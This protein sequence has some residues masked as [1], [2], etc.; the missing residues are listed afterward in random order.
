MTYRLLLGMALGL[1]P[2]AIQAQSVVSAGAGSYAST[3]PAYKS[4]TDQHEGFN[5]G[6]ML[7]RKI[8]C[9]ER[10]GRA[11]PTNDWWTDLINNRFSGSMWSYPAML[12]TGDYGV[13]ICY[14]SYWADEGKEI[15][16]RTSV[17]VSALSFSPEAAVASDW[18][19]LD[20]V[21][22]M[23]DKRNNGAEMKV[24]MAHGVPFTWFEYDSLVPALSFSDTPEFFGENK[25]K[26]F[27]GVRI[28]DDLYG[29]YYPAGLSLKES[30][31][32]YAL[33]DAGWVVVALLRDES[34][35]ERF[36]EYAP[37]VIRDSRISWNY[38]ERTSRVSSEWNIET[39]NL[40]KPGESTPVLLGL[41]PH[42]YKYSSTLPTAVNGLSYE[43]PRGEM[44]M[45]SDASGRFAYDCA[46]SG[47]LPYYAAPEENPDDEA[48]YSAEIMETLM[49]TYADK[50]T[51]GKDTYW[52]GKGL[53]QMALNMT[54]ARESG[55]EELYLKSR[56]KLKDALVDWLTYTPGEESCFFSYYP[57]WGSMLGFNVSYDSDAF[58]DHHF[59]YGYFTYAAALLCMEDPSFAADYGEI[60]TLIA[61]DY[62]NYDRQDT[63][64]PFL[65]TL[66]PWCGHSWAG[67]LGD[68]G[69]DNGNGQESTSE[70]MQS[71]GGLYLLGV[72][73]GDKE[74]RD[75]GIWGWNTEARATREYWFDVD[76]VRPANA[77]GRKPWA[78]KGDRKGNYDYSQY[79]YAYNSNI[80]GKGIGW[81]T[82]FGGDPL[83]MHGIQWMPVSPAL[84]YLSWDNDFVDWAYDDMMTGAN[85]TFSHEWF[86]PTYNTDNGDV[87][88]P[89]ADNDWGNVTLA[90]MQRSRPQE[91]AEIF[92]RAYKENRHIA[93]AVST[94]HI[95]YYL[96]HHHLTYGD[97]DFS[98]N[99]DIPTASAYLKD[100][101]YTFMVY[102]PD[103]DEKRV[104]F[105]RSGV[106]LKSVLAPAGRLTAFDAEP[107]ASSIV[108]E[109]SEGLIIPPGATTDITARVLDQ[110]GATAEK[111]GALAF[112]SDNAAVDVTSTGRV[113]VKAGAVKGT[114]FTITVTAGDLTE[115]LVFNIN[116][117]PVATGYHI[118]GLPEYIEKGTAFE[119]V[120]E[121]TDQ[122][123][124][125]TRPEVREWRLE[126]EDTAVSF[127]NRH[128]AARPGNFTL[129]AIIGGAPVHTADVTVLPQLPNAALEATAYSS[130]EENVGSATANVNDGDSGTRWGSRHTED[131]WVLLDFGEETYMTGAVVDWEAA[132]GSDYDFQVAPEGASM[133][134][135]TGSYAGV[136]RTITVPAESEWTTVAEVRG[137]SGAGKVSTS[138]NATGRYLRLK[139][140]TRGSAYG[141]SIHEMNVRG[142]PTSLSNNAPLGIDF[143]LPEVVDQNERVALTPKIYDKSGAGRPV[144]VNWSADKE[145]EFDGNTFVPLDY[146]TYELT[147]R[148][149]DG[150]FSSGSLFVNEG[151]RMGA[152]NFTP[153]APEGVT[154]DEISLVLSAS[155]QFGGLFDFTGID[156]KIVVTD[157]ATGKVADPSEVRYDWRNGIFRADRKGTYKVS[158]NDG[159]A[160]AVVSVMDVSE[161]NLAL[162][163]PATASASNGGNDAAKINDGNLGTRW[164]SPAKDNQWVEIDLENSYL[165]DHTV[166][167]WEG[168]YAK[169]YSLSVSTDGEN[170]WTVCSYKEG[171]GGTE[172]LALPAVPARFIRLDCER[173]A[174]VWGNS[175]YEWEVYGSARFETEDDGKAPLVDVLDADPGNGDVT[176]TLSAT[177]D[178]GY[179]YGRFEL[180]YAAGGKVGEETAAFISGES[181]SRTFGNLDPNQ[182]YVVT[183][184]VTDPFGNEVV[185][186]V[187]FRSTLDLT[188]KNIALGK[189]ATATSRENAGLDAEYAVDGDRS[190]RWGSEFR[191]NE[192]LD[193]DLGNVYSLTQIAI[194]WDQT[195]YS[196]DYEVEG[197]E[198]GSS[199][200]PIFS[201]EGWNGQATGDGCRADVFDIP[202]KTYARYLR[203]TSTKRATQ[204]GSSVREFEVYADNDF[205][206]TLTGV[207]TAGASALTDGRVYNLQG[208]AV[209]NSAADLE[210]NPLP[211]GIYITGGRKFTVTD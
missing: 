131:E 162:G 148:T 17:T 36:A 69:N 158:V 22:R 111:H 206:H 25:S 149:T 38:D 53:I 127:A 103:A 71:W 175:L 125:V 50:G 14:P 40:R 88:E 211:A 61:K 9:D 30:R 24:T 201:R 113:S 209:R 101:S 57:R 140:I 153:A 189:T 105:Y 45:Y 191:D 155:N 202:V 11:I 193:I 85:S 16:S 99:A 12:Q 86:T 94:G 67:G 39:D 180:A 135:Y 185:K 51:F 181:V 205:D 141:Y 23:P 123:G 91:A 150:L 114:P 137:N 151:V 75:A 18:H 169:D 133:T 115:T 90:Y 200:Y 177:D 87:N 100:G 82:W 29:I 122:Y 165:L 196:T 5:A 157:M 6:L 139:G 2:F 70:A 163:R 167:A 210:T 161:A 207:E 119:P 147:A 187:S 104:N 203:L 112:S 76:A 144:E 31:G 21:F 49:R 97:I 26:G 174:T 13:R 159:A 62:A 204:Y 171:K 117:R 56:A 192:V 121:V 33:T 66:D 120:L 3:P 72:A 81:W 170:W 28:G 89:L 160:E 110:Y 98:V 134:R 184:V 154:G 68:A 132:Y 198:T 10:D 124:N 107:V 92:S 145:A 179:V 178:S 19:D 142:I 106:L 186:T 93:S 79:K 46:F 74:M 143:G 64:F 164:E 128:V 95:S 52:G 109:S 47:M 172:T 195:A 4:K 126:G 156:I 1:C 59:H 73:L 78:G 55:N 182:E 27:C 34:D 166:L 96:I 80:T 15:K 60:L 7:T 190:T 152:M 102:N 146:G 138:L 188:G 208:I 83:F 130:S 8:Y 84:Q 37:G 58:N 41:L 48:G 63:R 199:Y 173:R 43:T 44:K 194:F 42:V 32:S 54:F 129:S 183:A 136:D 77:G 168:A 197:S 108:A 118:A 116:D 176:V 20:V 35:L 65:R